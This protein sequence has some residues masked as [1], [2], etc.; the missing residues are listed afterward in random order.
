MTHTLSDGTVL[1]DVGFGTYPLKGEDGVAAVVSA[2]EVGYR[3]LDTAVNYENETEVGQALQRSGLPRE[4][5][6]LATK[7]PGRFHE[8][9]LAL[10]S[11]R[12]SAARLGVERIDVGLIH[13]PNPSR[14]KYVQ[15]WRALVQAQAEG[16][17]THI[18]VSNFTAAHLDRIIDETGVTPALNQIELHP[19]FAQAEMRAANAE[20]GILTQAWSPLGKREAPFDES[21]VRAAA[22]RLEVTPAQVLLR[23]HLQVGSMPLPK[24]ATPERQLSNLDVSTFELTAAEVE[25]I[26]ALSRPDG[27]LFDGDPDTHEEM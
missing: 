12:D 19:R 7:I 20:R 10:Q 13:W 18:G 9:G 23:W 25:A 21:A 11:L 16:L 24:S 2:L 15:A 4:D 5:V 6:L 17:V 14:E 1:P 27:R 22:E 8:Q 26:S 3:Y